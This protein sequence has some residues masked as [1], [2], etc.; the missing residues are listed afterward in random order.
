MKTKTIWVVILAIL[1]MAVLPPIQVW[2]V[3]FA[4]PFSAAAYA[5][6]MI[7]GGYT[8]MD[9]LATVATSKKMPSGMKYTGSYKKLL[10]IVIAAWALAV[11]YVIFQS[12]LS[13]IQ[14][15][16][17]ELFITAGAVG[18]IFAGGN[19]LNN[20]AEKEGQEE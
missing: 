1:C 6:L 3:K 7:L 18:A 12:M 19:K 20:A 14:L 2:A 10:F 15:P 16:L 9:Q 8:G 11:E 4:L 17:S 5:L 13:E